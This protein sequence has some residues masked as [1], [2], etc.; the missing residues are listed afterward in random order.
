VVALDAARRRVVI[1]TRG[2][3]DCHELSADR[4]NWLVEGLPAT[5]SC[6]AQIRYTHDAA[7]ATVTWGED[8]TIRVTFEQ[9]QFGVAP[10]QAVVLYEGDRVLGGGWIASAQRGWQRATAAVLEGMER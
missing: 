10:G 3:L 9:P 2:D 1:G 8:Q 5:F 6:R 7:A 4:V